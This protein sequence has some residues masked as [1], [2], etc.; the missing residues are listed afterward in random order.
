MF[1]TLAMRLAADLVEGRNGQGLRGFRN[2]FR[3]FARNVGFGNRLDQPRIHTTKGLHVTG[4]HLQVHPGPVRQPVMHKRGC[5]TNFDDE[6][7]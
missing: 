1:F 3:M 6:M 4:P 5:E 2:M 7:L